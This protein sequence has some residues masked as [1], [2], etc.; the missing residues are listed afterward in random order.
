MQQLRAGENFVKL[1]AAIRVALAAALLFLFSGT[2]AF[3]HEGHHHGTQKQHAVTHI[4]RST[5]Q[6]SS[7]ASSLF[8]AKISK[9]KSAELHHATEVS[10]ASADSTPGSGCGPGCC[11]CG[12]AATCGMSAC[13]A[14]GLAATDGIIPHPLRSGKLAFKVSDVRT[15]RS[16]SGLDRPPKL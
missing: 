13:S 11:C 2:L 14:L 9:T 5:A 16:D 12:G 4:E 10:V 1:V 7:H 15:G 6:S 3:A 8:G